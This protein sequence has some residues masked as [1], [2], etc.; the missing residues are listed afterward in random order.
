[1]DVQTMKD[2]LIQ[3][4]QQGNA[5]R[6]AEILDAD[7]SL[8]AARG[9]AIL[10][11]IYHQHPEIAQLF[12]D[13]GAA[14]TFAEACAVGD[15]PRALALLEQDPSLLDR[16]SEDGFPPL[17]F[18]IFFRH[19]SLARTL[20]ERGADVNAP[21]ENAQRVA[22]VHAAASVGDVATMRLLLDHDADPNARQHN[23]YVP[24]HAAAGN[25]DLDM[26]RLLVARGADRHARTDDGKDAAA[27]AAERG[28]GEFVAWLNG[29]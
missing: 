1:M 12:V 13:R 21:A 20:I 10:L 18:A 5:A 6:A 19:P 27:L 15:E 9:N 26:A 8:I 2:E 22:P 16:R 3:A 23:G 14:L 25:G 11:A 4:I 24:L 29:L 28:R 7:P 17:G